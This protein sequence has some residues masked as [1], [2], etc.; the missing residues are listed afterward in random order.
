MVS[1]SMPLTHIAMAVSNPVV[2]N[3][4]PCLHLWAPINFQGGA[5][6]CALYNMQSLTKSI[7]QCLAAPHALLA[8]GASRAAL[9]SARP[10]I[11]GNGGAQRCDAVNVV[12]SGESGEE[13][14]CAEARRWA[15]R[16]R[17]SVVKEH[18]CRD[19]RC[20]SLRNNLGSLIGVNWSAAL[21][22]SRS[23]SAQST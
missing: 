1:T 10:V 19:A 23:P 8:S 17:V 3:Q 2:L 4:A 21:P 16:L 9:S 5:S 22:L 18:L 15:V 6:P 13:H 20:T 14:L 11:G 7:W 12:K